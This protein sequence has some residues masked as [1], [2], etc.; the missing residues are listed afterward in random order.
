MESI[1]KTLKKL[2]AFHHGA[3][4]RIFNIKWQQVHK[5]KIRN[6][7]VRFRSSNV[8]QVETFILYRTAKYLVKVARSKE[9]TYPKRFL[10]AWMN[11][12]K[13]NGGVEL[14]CTNTFANVISAILPPPKRT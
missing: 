6:K 2:E 13:K 7:Q 11:Q 12:P 10:G 9:R 5:D 14:S 1:S 4:R 3:A 8:P